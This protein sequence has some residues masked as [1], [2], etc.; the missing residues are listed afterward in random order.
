MSMDFYDSCPIGIVLQI[1][2]K[3]NLPPCSIP[4]PEVATLHQRAEGESFFLEQQPG[5]SEASKHVNL[6]SAGSNT[7]VYKSQAEL[8]FHLL[9]SY[10]QTVGRF[11]RAFTWERPRRSNNLARDFPI[12][13][14]CKF[15]IVSHPSALHPASAMQ[16][17][18]Q[19]KERRN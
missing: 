17:G 9:V 4:P 2:I 13:Q 5:Q 8:R 19:A 3:L 16:T 6:S 14:T 15:I 1:H 7:L 18:Q 12:G 10:P 11:G